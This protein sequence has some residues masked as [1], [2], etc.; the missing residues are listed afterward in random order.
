MNTNKTSLKVVDDLLKFRILAE[1][2]KSHFFSLFPHSLNTKMLREEI[3]PRGYYLLV[4]LRIS[5]L[6]LM[7][8]TVYLCAIAI[9]Y[10]R[11]FPTPLLSG[12]SPALDRDLLLRHLF[13][14][15]G[16]I[17]P[18]WFIPS[19]SST[20]HSCS[21]IPPQWDVYFILTYK[22]NDKYYFSAITMASTLD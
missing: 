15:F 22:C 16:T 9:L 8:F 7:L 5:H 10:S 14:Q 6:M 4:K 13:S 20:S 1:F 18:L 3:N 21:L 17:L 19:D 11:I 2:I 12:A